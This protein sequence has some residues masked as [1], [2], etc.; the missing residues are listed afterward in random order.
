[1]RRES[2]VRFC[3][4]GG[5]RFPSATR[6]VVLGKASPADMLAA[7]ETL[8]QPLKLTVHAEKTRCCR[9]PEESFDFLGYRIGRNYRPLGKG[10]YIGTRPSK[11]IVQSICRKIS[12]LTE[13]RYGLLQQ[14]VAGSS[15]WWSRPKP[16]DGSTATGRHHCQECV[17]ARSVAESGSATGRW[18]PLPRKR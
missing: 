9:V 1:M 10:S 7:V 2:H 12:E 3:E 13:P 5:V 8:M 6:L 15:V 14:E 16:R 18:P 17:C 11:A 4:G